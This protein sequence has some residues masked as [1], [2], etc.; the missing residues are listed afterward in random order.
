MP[1][2][3][4]ERTALAATYASGFF[5]LS[6]LQMVALATP[7]WGAHLGL[8][9]V[10]IGLAAG[11][12]SI[13][14]LVY[15]VHFGA[16]MDLVGVRRIMLFFAGQCALLP[17]LYPLLPGAFFFML[18]QLALGLAS[19]TIWLASQTAIAR[20]ASGDTRRTGLFSFLTSIGTVFG[21]LLLGFIWDYGGGRAGYLLIAAWGASLFAVCL[22][23]PKR[24]DGRRGMLTWRAFVPRLSSY[25]DG[26]RAL[27]QPLA[28]FV[29]ICAFLRL[30]GLSMLES[31]YPVLLQSLGY[32]AASIGM[33]FAIGNLTSSPSALMANGWTR[34]VGSERR[35]LVIA[36]AL[37]VFGITIAP[38]LPQF[39]MLAIGMAIY[40]F[41]LGVSMP[42]IFT[43]LSSGIPSDSQGLTAG[44]RATAN[45][46]AAVVLPI[47]MGLVAE[48]L[49]VA[50]AFWIVGGIL[51][52]ITW[53]TDIHYRS[54]VA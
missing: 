17:L 3:K 14:P 2:G 48:A 21:P 39:W 53:F 37:S 45:R 28:A 40:G 16:M 33:L 49:D 5:S 54:T 35:A 29:V 30:S 34:L 26:M 24:K 18:L 7:L 44:V 13:T 50:T 6:L 4:E 42:L 9:A 52:A 38:I 41:G 25:L 43:L 46:L 51:L 47:A 27:R 1:M 36:V 15:S 22:F 32:S 8:S 31:F 10:M 12:R 19:A 20:L 11:C 23:L